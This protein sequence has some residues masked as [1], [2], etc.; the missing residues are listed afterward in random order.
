MRSLL[1]ALV[2]LLSSCATAGAISDDARLDDSARETAAKKSGR[3]CGPDA[4]GDLVLLDATTG[5]SVPCLPVTVTVG[6]SDVYFRGLSGPRGQV[7]LLAPVQRA[8]LVAVADGFAPSELSNAT[9]AKDRVLELELAPAEGFWLK[10][11]DGEG[12]YLQDVQLTFKQGADVIAQ[13]RSNTLANVFFAGRQPFSGQPV[14]IEAVGFQPVTVSSVSELGED[15]HSLT[16][17]RQ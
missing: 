17:T 4:P 16:L 5:G 7:K 10:V 3:E 2:V 11:L 15:G 8:R 9:T 12:N 14:V 1:G 13:L 6:D